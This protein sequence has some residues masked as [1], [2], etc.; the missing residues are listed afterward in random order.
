MPYARVEP[1]GE[2][3]GHM[4]LGLRMFLEEGNKRWNDPCY[5]QVDRTSKEFLL[6]YQGLVDQEGRPLDEERYADWEKSLPRMWLAERLFHK[7]IVRFD[8]YTLRDEDITDAITHHLP[9]FYKAWCDEWDKVQGGMR[10]GWDV[11]CRKPRPTRFNKTQP[12]W[13][14]GRKAEVESKLAILKANLSAFD[15]QSTG[16]GEYFPAT[17]IDV[18]HVADKGAGGIIITSTAISRDNTANDT[19]SIDTFEMWVYWNLS[20]CKVGTFSGTSPTYTNR[21]Y[22]TIGAASS[23]AKR[24]FTGLDC[25][26]TT[27][28]VV[29]AYDSAGYLA[30][31]Y[32]GGDG[33]VTKSGDQF[34]AG[35]QTYSVWS[36]GA[37]LSLYGTGE[38][39]GLGPS[40]PPAATV[41]IGGVAAS[42]KKALTPVVATVAVLAIA[43]TTVLGSVT[44]TPPAATIPVAASYDG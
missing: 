27:G 1:I 25:D 6:G 44:I 31:Y 2:W 20:N 8:P 17:E 26:V 43:A 18:G 22:E 38:T 13:Y 4:K 11:A 10:H 24:T 33:I 14:A 29:G 28:D 7:H 40:T 37:W 35:E 16:E 41:A 34:G 36:S 23:G 5:Y 39:G 21:D 42:I 19:G 15:T 9:N 30:K 3:H 12:E 32:T